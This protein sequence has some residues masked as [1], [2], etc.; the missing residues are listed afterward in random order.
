MLKLFIGFVSLVTFLFYLFIL[1]ICVFGGDPGYWILG[2]GV[3]MGYIIGWNISG[4][5]TISPL[6]RFVLTD[7]EV[8]KTKYKYANGVAF[9][10]GFIIYVLLEYI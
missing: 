6:A 7:W 10:V 1:I 4:G 2:L 9:S 5:M 3:F 8:F